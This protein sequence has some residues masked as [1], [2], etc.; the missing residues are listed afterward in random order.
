MIS[1]WQGKVMTV[2]GLISPQK[3]GVTLVHEH[4]VIDCTA[5]RQE[6][7][8]AS[9]KKMA[10][11]PVDITH[12][13]VLR[14]EPYLSKDNC[15]ISD[16]TLVI[17]EL[18]Q[19]QRLGGTSLV[20]LTNIGIGRDPMALFQI[21]RETGLHIIMGCGYYVESSHPSDINDKS[22]DQIAEEIEKDITMG[23]DD[24]GIRAGIIGEIGT[25]FPITPNEE[26]ILR[27]SARA[28][29][30]TGIPISIHLWEFEKGGIK[31]LDI[32]EEEKVELNRVMM[33]HLNPGIPHDLDYHKEIA[34][35]GAYL[36][37]EFGH[38]FYYK[39]FHH[40]EPSDREYALAVSKL[41]ESGYLDQLLISQDVC[42]KINL[43]K[44]GG[45][46]YGHILRNIKT[47]FKDLGISEEEINIL[48]V[49]NPKRVLAIG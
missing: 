7:V 16:K 33:C 24:T 37:F 36:E 35:R 26:K 21:S 23:V 31:I 4:L 18:K 11:S 20:D 22:I 40:C 48:L 14:W 45:Y 13:G 25:S 3:L 34:K 12:L 15:L 38:G 10:S 17:E 8:E 1:G 29:L 41:I 43:T 30:K 2:Q 6:P 49:E 42:F 47:M 28:H 9:K 46:G 19:F 39:Q 27:A 5:W 32:L 44:Y